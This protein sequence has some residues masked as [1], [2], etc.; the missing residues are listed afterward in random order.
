MTTFGDSKAMNSSIYNW[1]NKN[2]DLVYDEISMAKTSPKISMRKLGDLTGNQ[3]GY[4]EYSNRITSG[5]KVSI[6]EMQP[7]HYKSP[8]LIRTGSYNM[9]EFNKG[10]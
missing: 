4:D 3:I 5:R 10:Y 2:S 9:K 8:K 1:K 6:Y 7:A